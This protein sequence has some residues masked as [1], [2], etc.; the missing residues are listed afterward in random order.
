MAPTMGLRNQ[1]C[2]ASLVE[3]VTITSAAGLTDIPTRTRVEITDPDEAASFLE[4]AYGV[5]L[6]LSIGEP[7]REGSTFLTHTRV[8]AGAFT[9]EDIS[10]AGD[11]K[12]AP[13]ALGKVRVLW[14]ERGMVESD[15]EG[16]GRRVGRDEIAMT[17]QHDLPFESHSVDV[18]V[19]SVL[20]DPA[21][22]ASVATGL[23]TAHVPGTVRFS[24]FDPVDAATGQLWKDT[25]TFVKN[26]VLNGGAAASPLV[27]G[28]AAR[29]L[30]A[31]TL[32]TFPAMPTPEIHP[33]DRT[34][35][36][37][38]LLRR[39]VEFIESNAASDIA[40]AD[41]ADAVHVSSRAVQYMFRRHLDT[42]PLQYLRNLRLEHAHADLKAGSQMHD[43]V[44]AIATR[45]GFAH[46]GRFA[47]LYRQTYGRS[48]H[49]TL[50]D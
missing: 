15:C 1:P 36:Q 7:Q 30:A 17:A 37:P 28:Q 42:T 9:V 18:K 25:F 12:S 3:V 50:R 5:R 49:E 6:R 4:T 33:F 32:T 20:L 11:I 41:I 47:V 2:S 48:P 31:A 39:A 24:G 16:M 44:T 38:V 43:T 35:H 23:P 13:D 45:W 8:E 29:M 14:V 46:T 10:I 19:T 34:D 27:L 21:L 26:T 22:V 40:L